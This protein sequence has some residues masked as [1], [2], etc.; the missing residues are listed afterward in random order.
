VPGTV[1]QGIAGLRL[2]LASKVNPVSL[3]DQESTTLF[4]LRAMLNNGGVNSAGFNS[5]APMS[6]SSPPEAWRI[7]EKS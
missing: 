7:E 6:L 2:A 5:N 3:V 4:A 1:V